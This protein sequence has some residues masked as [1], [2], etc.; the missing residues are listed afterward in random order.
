MIQVLRSDP[1][2]TSVNY[3]L[4]SQD[5]LCMIPVVGEDPV[6]PGNRGQH[7]AR[8]SGVTVFLGLVFITR[9]E[10]PSF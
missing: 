2:L 1:T 7:A 8:G 9:P 4:L 6:C 3:K 10:D 5:L